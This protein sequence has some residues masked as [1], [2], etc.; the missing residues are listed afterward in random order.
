MRAVAELHELSSGYP[1]LVLIDPLVQLFEGLCQ[2]RCHLWVAG[3]ADTVI[4]TVL[5]APRE[6]S[7]TREAAVGAHDDT[8]RRA[9]TPAYDRDDFFQCR[10]RSLAGVTLAVAQLRPQRDVAAKAVERQIAVAFVVTV[11]ISALLSPVQRIVGGIKIQH[12]LPAL[13]RDRLNPLGYQ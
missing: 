5:L 12:D 2:H 8:H 10:H 6:D 1:Q 3:E 4:K 9:K 13:A 7:F 11:K